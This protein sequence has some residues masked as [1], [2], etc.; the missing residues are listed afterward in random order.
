MPEKNHLKILTTESADK[1]A[2]A[3]GKIEEIDDEVVEVNHGDNDEDIE[4]LISEAGGVRDHEEEEIAQADDDEVESYRVEQRGQSPSIASPKRGLEEV[5]ADDSPKRRRSSRLQARQSLENSLSVDLDTPTKD[6]SQGR[7]ESPVES[8]YPSP[9]AVRSRSQP[10]TAAR[11]PVL[12][13]A[14]RQ[15]SNASQRRGA[16]T[17][18]S[19]FPTLA[20]ARRRKVILPIFT[21]SDSEESDGDG[22]DDD[23]DADYVEGGSSQRS[24][25]TFN[26][27]IYKVPPEHGGTLMVNVVDVTHQVVVNHLSRFLKHD[28]GMRKARPTVR[29]A[30]ARYR[31]L[32]HDHLLQLGDLVDS[33]AVLVARVRAAKAQR[34]AA[35]S[36]LL[37][38]RDERMRV[39]R[40]MEQVRANHVEQ[41][42]KLN[43]AREV[44]FFLADLAQ[45]RSRQ[46]PLPENNNED[47]D[48]DAS[49][50]KG[51][52]TKAL[53]KV[54]LEL[55]L[56]RPKLGK[57]GAAQ[58]LQK[59]VQKLEH[60]DQNLSF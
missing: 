3:A 19:V 6:R 2:P 35:R 25:D 26:L 17:T 53:Y 60:L 39:Q 44:D 27:T 4:K 48:D 34:D 7:L 29:R 51:A 20:N 32:V 41:T 30:F 58:I 57:A 49:N 28:K 59:A 45:S 54:L 50:G 12:A 13:K 18:A 24:H 47:D 11:A 1:N 22:A 9:V 36:R 40:R 5:G 37:E 56:L 16:L 15:N 52:G 21:Q 42:A 14:T 10:V 23:S 33:N 55:E 43:E 38:L 31:S 46:M 8:P